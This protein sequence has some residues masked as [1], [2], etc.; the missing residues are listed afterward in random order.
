[1]RR[2]LHMPDTMKI[3]HLVSADC[4]WE[5]AI[6][7]A[8]LAAALREHGVS[9]AVT[10]P[11]H[12]RLWE[13]AESAGVA[14]VP[15]PLENSINPLRWRELAKLVKEQAPDVVHLHDPGAA[16]LR[17]RAA[18]FG[19]SFPAVDSHHD[20]RKPP[21]ASE[22]DSGVG[23]VICPSLMLADTFA[24]LKAP[25][26]KVRVIY[27]GVS[28]SGADNAVEDRDAL[29]VK[30]RDAYCPAKDKPLFLVNI[31][32]LEADSRQG[33][34]LEAMAEV[35]AALP[36]A[37][38]FIMGEGT[39]GEELSRQIRIMALE[40][41]VTVLEPER[42]FQRLLAA[43]DL[44]VSASENDGAGFMVQS[45]MASGR[46]VALRRAGC[47][48]ELVENG[49]TGVLAET[50][51]EQSLKAAI[52]ELL[53]NRTGREQLGRQAR[54]AAGKMFDAAKQA[55]LVAEVY[56]GLVGR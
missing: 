27:E 15:H 8:T 55:G 32:P 33:E 1:M 26:G 51:Q 25:E 30:F 5:A 17:A 40:R 42:A 11:D 52:L 48:P 12:S 24:K 31:A 43:A 21:A 39:R 14:V 37:H 19:A 9:S 45:A 44:Y 16:G 3:L 10:A 56:R 2:P 41:E 20:A 49:K 54:A 35:A 22:Y 50:G 38:L 18:R 47:Y 23:A 7:I 28:L 46:A 13:F 29:R 4:E 36:Q 34:I 53:E 6:S